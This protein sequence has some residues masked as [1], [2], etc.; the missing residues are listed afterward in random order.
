MTDFKEIIWDVGEPIGVIVNGKF[1]TLPSSIGQDAG[2]STRE[3]EFDSPRQRHAHVSP[4]A[5]N[6]E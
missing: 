3:G 4:P 2:F 5:T 1:I 6:R